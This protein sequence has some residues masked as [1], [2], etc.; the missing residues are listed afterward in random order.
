MFGDH[1]ASDLFYLTLIKHPDFRCY[2]KNKI[3]A[4]FCPM[5]VLCIYIYCSFT[6]LSWNFCNKLGRANNS[7]DNY[8]IPFECTPMR[9]LAGHHSVSIYNF[10]RC[11]FVDHNDP[12]ILHSQMVCECSLCFILYY[13]VFL[14]I[15]SLIEVRNTS[16]QYWFAFP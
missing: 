10:L 2:H 15:T 16:L 11:V 6:Y 3:S 12:V 1:P 9:R 13:F 14:I 8:F 5:Y 4:S 7:Q